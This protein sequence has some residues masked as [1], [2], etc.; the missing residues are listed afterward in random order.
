MRAR[1]A[2]FATKS[3]QNDRSWTSVTTLW[4]LPLPKNPLDYHL[5]RDEDQKCHFIIT[6]YTHPAT[7][8]PL[9]GRQSVD[10]LFYRLGYTVIGTYI[11]SKNGDHFSCLFLI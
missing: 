3:T 8:T 10:F 4:S 1:L 6:V 7:N 2:V 11:Y 9:T 5:N